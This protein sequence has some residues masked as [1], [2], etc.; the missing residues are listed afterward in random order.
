LMWSPHSVF[1]LLD[2]F[3]AMKHGRAIDYGA[4]S[5]RLVACCFST[6]AQPGKE[7]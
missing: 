1:S 3:E 7:I 6:A 4:S 5:W 2:H